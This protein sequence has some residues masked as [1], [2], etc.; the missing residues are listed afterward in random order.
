MFWGCGGK[1]G[2]IVTSETEGKEKDNPISPITYVFSDQTTTNQQWVLE[3]SGV[4]QS[5]PLIKWK[6]GSCTWRVWVLPR[7]TTVPMISS[8]YC[9]SMLDYDGTQHLS[10]NVPILDDTSFVHLSSSSPTVKRVYWQTITSVTWWLT[11]DTVSLHTI[12][13]HTKHTPTIWVCNCCSIIRND[14][15]FLF[16]EVVYYESRKRDWGFWVSFLRG[17]FISIREY[18]IFFL[19]TA[20]V[21]SSSL[22]LSRIPL[23]YSSL[24]LCYISCWVFVAHVPQGRAAVNICCAAIDWKD[25]SWC[26]RVRL[27]SFSGLT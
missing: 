16:H 20:V 1:V 7:W 6:S 24:R 13:L 4:F 3:C 14:D 11:E 15:L 10:I 17:S 9:T 8:E 19:R 27:D 21:M 23:R 25:K 2:V 18:G 22:H 12:C 5:K 26:T